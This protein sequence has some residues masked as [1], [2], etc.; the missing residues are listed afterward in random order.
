MNVPV[1]KSK[2]TTTLPAEGIYPAVL[3]RII[4]L[5]TQNEMFQNQNRKV[6][7]ILLSFVIPGISVM[8][9]EEPRP[10][11]IHREYTESLWETA[12]LRRDLVKM[13]GYNFLVDE[14][15]NEL[16]FDLSS[17]L[18]FPLLITLRHRTTNTP[19]L[20]AEVSAYAPLPEDELLP[21]NPLPLSVLTFQNF[22]WPLYNKLGQKLRQ[23]IASAQEY[24]VFTPEQIEKGL[25]ML[26]E[27][28][29]DYNDLPF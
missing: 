23:R 8:I 1:R 10:Y 5:G 12:H 16:D 6:K 27:Q 20:I 22:N 26:D 15:E 17:L 29:E 13:K 11:I 21:E 28:P 19:T 7:K 25:Q 2:L 9:K 3:C 14:A 18:G 24:K 4:Q